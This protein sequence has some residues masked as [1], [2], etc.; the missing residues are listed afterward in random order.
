MLPLPRIAYTRST[1]NLI[2]LVPRVMVTVGTMFHRLANWSTR[3][4]GGKSVVLVGACT[5]PVIPRSFAVIPLAVSA[6][7]NTLVKRPKLARRSRIA[8]GVRTR[9]QDAMA[10]TLVRWLLILPLAPRPGMPL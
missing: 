5:E 7:G 8:A 2:V 9:V 3:I 10:F 6:S 1:P 4:R